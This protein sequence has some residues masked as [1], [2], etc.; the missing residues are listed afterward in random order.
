[1]SPIVLKMPKLNS[2]RAWKRADLENDSSWIYPLSE[3]EIQDLEMGLRAA[4]ATGKSEF[5]LSASDFPVTPLTD[6]TASHLDDDRAISH[7]DAGHSD[8]RYRR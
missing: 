7:I 1:M 6:T 5:E 8:L 4:L 2:P 3:Q